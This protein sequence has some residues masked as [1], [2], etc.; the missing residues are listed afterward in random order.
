MPNDNISLPGGFK[1][2]KGESFQKSHKGLVLP[3]EFQFLGK[4]YINLQYRLNKF[5][6]Q[7][8]YNLPSGDTFLFDSFKFSEQMVMKNR[9]SFPHFMAITSSLSMY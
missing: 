8:P 4:K 9:M 6:Y 1:I 7:I 5:S 2:L 3:S